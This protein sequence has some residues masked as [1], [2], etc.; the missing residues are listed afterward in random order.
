MSAHLLPWVPFAAFCGACY[1]AGGYDPESTPEMLDRQ[2]PGI[3]QVAGFGVGGVVLMILALPWLHLLNE[4]RCDGR[5]VRTEAVQLAAFA[6]LAV[7]LMF[8]VVGGYRL[9]GVVTGGWSADWRAAAVGALLGAALG[10]L[11]G[12]G[13]ARLRLAERLGGPQ[14]AEPVAAPDP[15]T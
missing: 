10:L 11:L 1:A 5:R 6:A 14:R 3:V 15:A 9:A 13:S 4:G 2:L 8:A 7:T 12:L